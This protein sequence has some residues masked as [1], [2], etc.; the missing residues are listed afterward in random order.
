VG[1]AG[2][3]MVPAEPCG[4]PLTKRRLNLL[5]E[6]AE[7]VKRRGIHDGVLDRLASG[8]VLV[9]TQHGIGAPARARDHAL[10]CGRAGDV[11]AIG[12]RL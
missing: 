9:E 12:L 2:I 8:R 11:S 1:D 6:L 4:A 3:D 10:A 7:I 5:I